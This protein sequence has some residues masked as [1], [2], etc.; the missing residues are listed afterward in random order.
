M[1]RIYNNLQIHIVPTSLMSLKECFP[2]LWIKISTVDSSRLNLSDRSRLEVHDEDDDFIAVQYVSVAVSCKNTIK[3][4][5]ETIAIKQKIN[6]SISKYI[7]VAPVPCI[8]SY[9][10]WI[11]NTYCKNIKHIGS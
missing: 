6:S 3:K 10:V 9:A 1:N 8:G 5:S 7:K 11:I 4:T 2:F